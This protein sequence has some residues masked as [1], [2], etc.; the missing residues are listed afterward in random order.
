MALCLPLPPWLCA[1]LCPHGPVPY[2]AVMALRLPVQSWPCVSLCHHGSVP[3]CAA[4][5]LCLSVPPCPFASLC[6]YGP[7]SPC[8]S[9]CRH[10]PV[11]RSATMALCLLMPRWPFASLCYHDP[12]PLFDA[13][14]LYLSLLS[15]HCAFLCCHA[16]VSLSLPSWPC[17]SLYRHVLVP[18]SAAMALPPHRVAMSR[19]SLCRIALCLPLP[20]WHCAPLCCHGWPKLFLSVSAAKALCPFAVMP[21]DRQAPRAASP[22]LFTSHSPQFGRQEGPVEGPLASSRTRRRERLPAGMS[23]RRRLFRA[24]MNKGTCAMVLRRALAVS[25][26]VASDAADICPLFFAPN[27]RISKC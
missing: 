13:M 1:S 3:L 10:G 5:A 17:L 16:P 21:S 24:K 2:S 20:T 12:V 27:K 7:V 23:A 6:R 22:P 14:V 26:S 15:W 4:M 8:A 18:P 19:A 11:P 9:L 25:R